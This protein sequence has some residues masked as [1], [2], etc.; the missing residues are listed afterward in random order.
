MCA[1]ERKGDGSVG[2]NVSWI[3]YN[4]RI[5]VQ[6]ARGKFDGWTT[7]IAQMF[8]NI[9]KAVW[10]NSTRQRISRETK[11]RKREETT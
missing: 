7:R 1:K 8:K 4:G 9:V 3:V 11:S 10:K 2:N 5:S 6:I